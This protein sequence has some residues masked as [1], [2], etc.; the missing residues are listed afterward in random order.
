MNSRVRRRAK[1]L[2]EIF[3]LPFQ[4][5]SFVPTG[6]R[7]PQPRP[8]GAFVNKP[9]PFFNFLPDLLFAELDAHN[10]P[11]HLVARQRQGDWLLDLG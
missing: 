10:F 4:R 3:S 11:R 1:F 7:L 9:H 6:L 5:R 2:G 8:A